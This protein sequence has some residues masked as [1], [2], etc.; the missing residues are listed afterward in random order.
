MLVS[1]QCLT[2]ADWLITRLSASCLK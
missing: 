2:W 1:I